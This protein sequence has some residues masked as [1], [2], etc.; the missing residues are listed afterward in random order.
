MATLHIEHAITDVGTWQAAFARFA[1]AR[2]EAG[3]LAARIAQPVDDVH[4]V[5]VDLDFGTADEASRFLGFLREHVWA[6]RS[7][8]PALTGEPRTLVL[9]AVPQNGARG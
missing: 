1:P 2:A 9:E 4:Y 6:D 3:V 5:V 7:S 8:S